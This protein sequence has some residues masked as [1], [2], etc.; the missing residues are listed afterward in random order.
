MKKLTI[1]SL[2]VVTTLSL[3]AQTT[4]N[5]S[6]YGIAWTFN[7]QHQYG[8]YA[9]G[10]YWVLGPVTITNITPDYINGFNGWEVNPADIIK[11]GF[12][13]RI[14]NF[15]ATKIPS[16]PY[17]AQPG[18]SIVKTISVDTTISGQHWYL[19]TAAVLTVVG[20]VPANN[21]STVFRP[22]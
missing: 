15:D 18:E 13:K 4:N 11:Q 10:D 20:S 14:H 17:I 16:L 5:I 6:Q 3:Y 21:G 12:D 19:Q 8:Q 1:L 22:P 7:A 2:V 9:N